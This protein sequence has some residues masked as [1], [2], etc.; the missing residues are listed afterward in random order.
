MSQEEKE[1][2]LKDLCGRLPYHPQI[3]VYVEDIGGS[4]E[5]NE[6]L[7]T[8]DAEVY[9][10]NDRHISEDIKPYLRSISNMTEEEVKTYRTLNIGNAF[11]YV[12]NGASIDYLNSIHIDYRG[13]IPLGLAL[14]APEGM[15]K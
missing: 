9:L 15:Y 7:W 3:Y 1:L 12:D 2:L 5:F 14:E 13:L 6:P 8:I 4:C 11:L 10:V